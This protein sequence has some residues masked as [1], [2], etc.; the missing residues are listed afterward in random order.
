[1]NGGNVITALGEAAEGGLRGSL[2]D[3]REP[4]K[5]QDQNVFC[6]TSPLFRSVSLRLSSQLVYHHYQ[7]EIVPL[8]ISYRSETEHSD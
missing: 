1:M 6:S 8:K 3:K 4:C 5:S 2:C 7:V